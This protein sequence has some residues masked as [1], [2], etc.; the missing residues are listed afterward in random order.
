MHDMLQ[1]LLVVMVVEPTIPDRIAEPL[2]DLL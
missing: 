2:P 1:T